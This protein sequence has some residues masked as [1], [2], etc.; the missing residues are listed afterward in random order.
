MSSEKNTI[1]VK[2]DPAIE[3]TLTAIID[4]YKAAR[5]ELNAVAS[6]A[7]T[8]S[9]DVAKALEAVADRLDLLGQQA[10]ELINVRNAFTS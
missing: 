10:Q 9:S 7:G 1:T 4:G 8:H 6:V 2:M 5:I 3:K